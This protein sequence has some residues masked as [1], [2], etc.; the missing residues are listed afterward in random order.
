MPNPTCSEVNII[1]TRLKTKSGC[2]SLSTILDK[3]GNKKKTELIEF[4]MVKALERA[5]EI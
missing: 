5:H 2:F 4:T 3:P 1:Q